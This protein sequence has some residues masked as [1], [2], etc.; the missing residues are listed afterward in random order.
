VTF[1]WDVNPSC[2][3]SFANSESRCVGKIKGGGGI[4]DYYLKPAALFDLSQID[5]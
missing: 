4:A 1:E 5:G 2:S 3:L